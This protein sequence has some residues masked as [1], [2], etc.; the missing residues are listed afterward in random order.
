MLANWPPMDPQRPRSGAPVRDML[1]QLYES[2]VLPA[3]DLYLSDAEIHAEVAVPGADPDSIQVSLDGNTVTVTGVVRPEHS[4]GQP[5]VE[6]I[7]RGAFRQSFT[8]PA[9]AGHGGAEATYRDG[10]LRLKLPRAEA[11][12]PELI[13]VRHDSG[14][15]AADGRL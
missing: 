3:I 2:G 13:P 14:A 7:W 9:P 4:L 8:L 1:N 12:R 15:R 5:F 11:V 10:M 6:D